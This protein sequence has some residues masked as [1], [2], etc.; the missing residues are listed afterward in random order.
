MKK[1]FSLLLGLGLA[2]VAWAQPVESD[3]VGTPKRTPEELQKLLAPIAIYPDALVA[4]I[5]PSAAASSDVV[6]AARFLAADG[7]A[8]ELD[9]QSWDPSVIALAHYPELVKWMDQNLEWTREVGEAFAIQPTDVMNAVQTLRAN[10]QKSGLLADTPQQRVIVRDAAI[11][12]EPATDVIYVPY[13]DPDIVFYHRAPFGPWLTFSTGFVV[14][15]W[16]NYDCDWHRHS[17]WV[18]HRPPGWTYRPGWRWH[19][20][21]PDRRIV[22]SP[23]RPSPG[24]RHR[25]YAH[26]PNR[27][28]PPVARPE[29][30]RDRPAGQN[31]FRDGNRSS[32]LDRG[33]RDGR[34][35]GDGRPGENNRRT[36]SGQPSQANAVRQGTQSWGPSVANNLVQTP[37]ANPSPGSSNPAA[38]SPAERPR[39][40]NPSPGGFRRDGERRGGVNRVPDA[41]RAQSRSSAASPGTSAPQVQRPGGSA[42]AAGAGP[43]E[44]GRPAYRAPASSGATGASHP[45][46]VSRSPAAARIERPV[47]AVTPGAAM[48]SAGTRSA[49]APRTA[50][51]NGTRGGNRNHD[52]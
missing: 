25:E 28:R 45:Q 46:A 39:L 26:A 50:D 34:W 19:D 3:P 44:G 31:H 8:T 49:P 1:L 18:Y 24:Y 2:A 13:Y 42:R 11:Y 10:A 52:R 16:L 41:G 17:I 4:L 51:N 12:I 33:R 27:P 48:N 7:K 14:G 35:S 15:S 36:H 43:R 32:S 37:A 40:G 9:Q 47:Q 21:G 5:L 23:W 29:W 22:R 20:H 6:L 38:A 30:R